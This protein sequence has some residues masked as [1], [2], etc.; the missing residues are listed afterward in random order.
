MHTDAHPADNKGH[1]MTRERMDSLT[2]MVS[3]VGFPIM[4]ALMLLGAGW[5]V[6]ER[7]VASH[8][9]FLDSISKTVE[10]QAESMDR[11]VDLTETIARNQKL[12]ADAQIE[13]QR[14]SQLILSALLERDNP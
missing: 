8:D 1:E 11:L 6:G 12:A 9:A 5:K 10:Q 4:V 14:T 13:N 3:R 2:L 7:L